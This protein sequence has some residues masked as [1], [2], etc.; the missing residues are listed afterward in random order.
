MVRIRIRR[1]TCPTYNPDSQS[2]CLTPE[3]KA[4]QR[5][6]DCYS[7]YSSCF[8]TPQARGLANWPDS[9]G[10]VTRETRAHSATAESDVGPTAVA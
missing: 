10:A 9:P 3:A 2:R 7:V 4:M 8:D 1:S 6:L 5:R